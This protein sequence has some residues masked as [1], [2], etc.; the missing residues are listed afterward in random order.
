MKR[1]L[2][3][4]LLGFFT[5]AIALSY[6]ATLNA[7]KFEGSLEY[8]LYTKSD[9]SDELKE[10]GNFFVHFAP[11]RIM[12]NN[13]SSYNFSSNPFGM[14]GVSGLLLREDEQDFVIMSDEEKTALVIQKSS[15]DAFI[16]FLDNMSDDEE[17]KVKQDEIDFAMK[18]DK[19]KDVKMNVAGVEATL[20]VYE[21]TDAQGKEMKYHVWTPTSFSVNWGLLTQ[22][23]VKKLSKDTPSDFIAYFKEGNIPLRMEMF[24][25]GKRVGYL[26]CITIDRK[27]LPTAMTSIPSGYE[28]TDLSGL[29][30]KSL[31]GN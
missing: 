3:T 27:K 25:D 12:F 10:D 26:E 8:R 7:Q 2:K 23:W 1:S 30:F 14:D 15:I 11:K 21:Q 5:L 24:E 19:R 9:K 29:I 18:V 22:P 31:M 20:T 17:E 6:N 13:K 28:K 16:T 4:Y